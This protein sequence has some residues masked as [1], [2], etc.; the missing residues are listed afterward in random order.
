[1]VASGS[2]SADPGT[3]QTTAAP[4][5]TDVIAGQD[6]LAGKYLVNVGYWDKATIAQ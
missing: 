3:P 6:R 2:I 5:I 1:M 4:R